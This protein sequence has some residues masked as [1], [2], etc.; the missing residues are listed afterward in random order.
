[1]ADLAEF[2]PIGLDTA[3]ADTTVYREAKARI[4]ATVDL[5]HLNPHSSPPMSDLP[6][7]FKP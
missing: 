6:E 5:R 1:V 7:A 4:A 2:T 3:F